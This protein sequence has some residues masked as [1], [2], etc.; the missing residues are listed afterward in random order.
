MGPEILF[1]CQYDPLLNKHIPDLDPI[2]L[3][4]RILDMQELKR[5]EEFLS[6]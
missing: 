5:R 4:V 3:K 1:F 6:S 2:N